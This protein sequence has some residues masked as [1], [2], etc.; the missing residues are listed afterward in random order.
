MPSLL[1]E[2]SRVGESVQRLSKLTQAQGRVEE[3]A[4]RR[5]Q[6]DGSIGR[7]QNAVEFLV[8]ARAEQVEVPSNPAAEALL[9]TVRKTRESYLKDPSLI[10]GTSFLPFSTRL[11]EAA[12]AVEVTARDVWATVRAQRLTVINQGLLVSLETLPGYA[13]T[14][15]ELRRLNAQATTFIPRQLISG[16]DLSE[17][18]QVAENLRGQ[19]QELCSPERM[20]AEVI[21]FLQKCAEGGAGLD[22][23]TAGVRQWLSDNSLE[24]QFRVR[25]GP[26]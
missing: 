12:D 11:R 23:L 22:L 3:F 18:L 16:S 5:E 15:N 2:I 6:L 24:G 4:S 13:S 1:A 25:M 9:A 10:L 7:I 20:P 26:G 19:W 21:T 17:F 8:A 14:V